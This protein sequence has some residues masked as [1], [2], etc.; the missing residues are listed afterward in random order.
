MHQYPSTL[1]TAVDV[2]NQMTHNI[3]VDNTSLTVSIATAVAVL[4]A[5]MVFTWKAS[6]ATYAAERT[7]HHLANLIIKFDGLTTIVT[8][9]GKALAVLMTEMSALKDRIEDLEDNRTSSTRRRGE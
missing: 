7:N 4:A 1:P 8:D 6:R 9:Q 2:V 5:L 3:P